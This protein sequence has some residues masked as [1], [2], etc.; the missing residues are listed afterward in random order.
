MFAEACCPSSDQFDARLRQLV[1]EIF[2][3]PEYGLHLLP[4]EHPA[5]H[6]E[7]IVPPDLHRP[8]LARLVA[9]GAA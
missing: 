3:E 4:P 6:A 2:P 9:A 1:G 7:E 5:W 8:L